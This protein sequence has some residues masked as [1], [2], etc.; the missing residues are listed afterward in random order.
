MPTTIARCAL[1]L[2]SFLLCNTA[3][4]VWFEAQGQA[5]IENDNLEVARQNATQEAI[6]QAL[7]FAG[8]SI[9][10][11]QRMA[12]GLLKDDQLIIRSAGEVNA[13][14]LIEE[15]YSDGYVTVSIRADIFSQQTTCDGSDYIKTIATVFHEVQQREQATV[16]Q[17]FDLG[18]VLPTRL[19]HQF[20]SYAQHTL[21][22]A[23]APYYVA[24]T[25]NNIEQQ[26]VLLARKTNSQYVLFA[27]VTDLTV[28]TVQAP[29]LAF[30]QSNQ[31][32]RQFGYHLQ[33]L[34]GQTG[35]LVWQKQYQVEAPWEFDIHE[36][37]GSHN[38][39]LWDSGFGKAVSSVLQDAAQQID[40]TLACAPA[41]GRVLAVNNEQLRINI[42]E[43]QG[44]RNGD[45][46]T[47]YQ[48]NQFHDPQGQLH[49]QYNLHPST[50][51]V[52]AVFANSAILNAADGQ[53]L[54][55]IQPNDF[56]ARR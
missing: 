26:A 56:V 41:Y 45:E 11:V 18:S 6:K 13:I 42:G 39:Q 19:Q 30:W 28:T 24:T 54:G 37:V 23:I 36:T 8:A 50:M 17:L 46:M 21:V 38:A 4:G 16:G 27:Q 33:L 53:F 40:E 47:L 15:R 12:D 2:M 25:P 9:K 1:F 7:L 20:D 29:T 52:V 5:A 44:V 22:Q 43:N 35:S 48:I 3:Y 55:N 14:E 34:D 32:L 51:K 31:S 10:S 49:A